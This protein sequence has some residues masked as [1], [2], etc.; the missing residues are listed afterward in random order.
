M[1]AQLQKVLSRATEEFQLTKR[2]L[3]INPSHPLVEHL[4][5]LSAND[6]HAAFIKTCGQQFLA[7]AM[8]AEGVV[9]E[10]HE[11]SERMMGFMEEL[12]QQ[13]SPIAGA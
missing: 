9:P 13:R 6:E 4:A 1:S 7:N 10:P 12:A 3:E 5:G 11:T 2:I 8:L